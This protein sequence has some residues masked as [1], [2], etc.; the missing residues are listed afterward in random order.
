MCNIKASCS[1]LAMAKEGVIARP[2][3]A[4]QFQEVPDETPKAV[5]R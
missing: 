2:E 4:V 5:L 1:I 3:T